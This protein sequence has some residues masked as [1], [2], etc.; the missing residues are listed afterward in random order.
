M[1]E[2]GTK[3]KNQNGGNDFMKVVND[4]LKDDKARR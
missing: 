3:M 2:K 4:F 1:T